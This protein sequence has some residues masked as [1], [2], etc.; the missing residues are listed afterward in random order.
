MNV[1]GV[2]YSSDRKLVRCEQAYSYR[3]DEKLKARVKGE[4]LFRGDWLHQLLESYRKG[5]N[6]EDKYDELVEKVWDK[7]FDEQKEIYGENFPEDICHLFSHYVDH[8][9]GQDAQLRPIHIEQAFE[10]MVKSLGA[11]V[12]FK[13]DYIAAKGKLK[14][15]FENKNKK[16]IPEPNERILDRQAHGY[17]YLLS[18]LPKPIIIDQIVW[19]YIRTT[20]V[21]RPQ[22]LKS[23]KLSERAINTDRRSYLAAMKE[24]GIHPKGD[25][26]IG[27][28]NFLKSLPETLTLERVINKP[29]FK[30][31][32][33]VVRDW[34]DRAKR[35]RDITRPTRNWGK[36]CSWECDYHVL[37]QADMIGKPDRNTIVKRDF[38]TNIKPAEELKELLE[39]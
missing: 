9:G 11:P 33:I 3:Y 18:K 28:E 4:G 19:D 7:L 39:K 13:A 24:A 32:E 35:A 17:C 10:I 25:E 29:N 16:K 14:V 37:C 21:P 15:L 23:G 6:W 12:R 26:I 1:S 34:I 2:S 8:W 27:V 31:G 36:T 20:P 22:I 30:V 38:V 5:E